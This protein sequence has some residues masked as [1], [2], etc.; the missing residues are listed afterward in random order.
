MVTTV[1]DQEMVHREK[2]CIQAT[3]YTARL[4]MARVV[5]CS[6]VTT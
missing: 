2:Y 1:N 3:L 6:A 4:F 5:P